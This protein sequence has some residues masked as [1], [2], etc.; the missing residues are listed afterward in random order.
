MNLFWIFCALLIVV[1]LMFVVLPLWR[2]SGK[3]EDIL[4]DMSN[5]EISRDQ[6][7]ELDADLRNGLLTQEFYDQAKRELQAR[8]LGEVKSTDRAAAPR[9]NNRTLAIV[10]AVLLPLFTVP[11]YLHLGSP[12]ASQSLK[13]QVVAG[14]DGTVNSEQSVKA[15][16]SEV[17]KHP[18]NPNAWYMLAQ[19]YIK[20]QRYAEASDAYA[21]L[22]KIVPEEAQV[23]ANYADVYAMAHGKTL[24]SK[25]V[26]EM[27]SRALSLNEN[28]IS[29]LALSGSAGMES[30][31]Y[32]VAI[33]SWQKLLNQL[34]PDSSDAQ[35]F[36]RDIQEARDLLAAQPGGKKKLADL[37]KTLAKLAP[38]DAPDQGTGQQA[39][40]PAAT[41]T[42]KVSLSPALAGKV[43]PTDTVFILARAAQGPK[44]PLAVFRKQ[45]KDLPLNFA[46]D[47]SMAMRQELRLSGFPQVIVVAR[48]SKSGTPMPRPGDLEGMTGAVKPGSKGLN[49]VIDSV[50]K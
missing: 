37:D 43:N 35:R 20:Q 7:A 48:V 41:L 11:L 1:A 26:A 31:D 30:K 44:M 33:T 47:D 2:Q 45:V 28:N 10:L 23:W 24:L 5:L 4:R 6:L 27:L 46:L 38:I 49:V 8:M 40:D 16:E 22:V 50:V 18:E 34:Q 19:A 3:N 25:E 29:A 14:S 9:S 42:G 21:E 39:T 15:L 13:D 12:D 36:V 17:K 32:A